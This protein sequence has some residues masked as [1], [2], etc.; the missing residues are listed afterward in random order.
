[1]NEWRTGDL[2]FRWPH[3]T[4]Q[5]REKKNERD[6][7]DQEWAKRPRLMQRTGGRAIPT[8]SNDKR[9]RFKVARTLNDMMQVAA[10][11]AAVFMS[12]QKCPYD[13]EF[14]GNDLCAATHILGYV[15]DEPA[16]CLR[17]SGSSPTSRKLSGSPCA[18]STATH[19]CPSRSSGL[20]LSSHA[21]RAIAPCTGMLRTAW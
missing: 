18:M 13:E 12:E 1:M 16:A 4:C 15:N 5:G 21:R 8:E 10:I 2:V 3:N 11:R 6:C 19:A 14:D 7:A 17:E 9:Y 20:E